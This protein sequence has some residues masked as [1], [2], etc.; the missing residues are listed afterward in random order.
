[1]DRQ[2]GW[3]EEMDLD[4]QEVPEAPPQTE[5]DLTNDDPVLPGAR[6]FSPL[7]LSTPLAGEPM[8]GSL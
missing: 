4:W 7:R 1:M 5:P 3:G 2:P 8:E 6:E